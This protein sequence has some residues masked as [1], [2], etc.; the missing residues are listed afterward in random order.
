MS[1]EEVLAQLQKNYIKNIPEKLK[2]MKAHIDSK[3][4][5]ALREEFHKIKG[6][7]RTHG[8]P[9]I[10]DLGSVFEEILVISNFNPQ[11]N[12]ALDAY[13]IFKDIYDS[14]SKAKPFNIDQDPR[15]KN[16]QSTLESFKK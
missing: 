7:G 3:D 13:D 16:L 1:L 12:W 2:N 11:I 8:L 9:E 15:Y 6:T 10:T 14:R 5:K 4:Y